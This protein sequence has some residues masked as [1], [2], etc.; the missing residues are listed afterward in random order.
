MKSRRK[1]YTKE[2]L[3]RRMEAN[4]L[5]HADGCWIWNGYTRNGYGS[6]SVNDHP[7][8]LHHLSWELH[9]GTIPTGK[10]VLHQCDNK[11]CWKPD[12]LFLGTQQDNVD[13]MWSKGRARVASAGPCAARGIENFNAVHEDIVVEAAR[14]MSAAGASQRKVARHFNVSQRTVWSWLHNAT[15]AA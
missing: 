6:F 14:A 7:T 9:F 15:R 4:T 12:C 2:E 11:R 13:D 5:K 10:F 1:S 8:Y 3:L